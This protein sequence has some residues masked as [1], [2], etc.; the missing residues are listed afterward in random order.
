MRTTLTID[1]DNAFGLKKI[2]KEFPERSFK[3]VL[4][5]VIRNG[6]K[7]NTRRQKKQERFVVKPF[8]L[9]LR[10]GLSY[11]NI[12]ELLDIVEGPFRR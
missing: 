3:E 10:E 12:E 9:G 1:D 4:N 6:L 8:N 11:D 2:Q 5:D 7:A